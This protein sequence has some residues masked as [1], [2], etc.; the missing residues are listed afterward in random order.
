MD[1]KIFGASDDTS[2]KQT[3]FCSE[4]ERRH[5]KFQQPCLTHSLKNVGY[6]YSYLGLVNLWC[7]EVKWKMVLWWLHR[8]KFV[9]FVGKNTAPVMGHDS[10]LH[11]DLAYFM[12]ILHILLKQHAAIQTWILQG[13][14]TVFLEN[15]TVWTWKQYDCP[16]YLQSQPIWISWSVMGYQKLNPLT[17]MIPDCCRPRLLY[18]RNTKTDNTFSNLLIFKTKTTVSVARHVHTIGH[19]F[20]LWPT[21][22]LRTHGRKIVIGLCVKFTIVAIMWL[23]TCTSVCGSLQGC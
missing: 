21:D 14:L 4:D 22:A 6:I 11:W 17:K 20:C 7:T 9:I 23:Q 13:R 3:C 18:R 15:A 16:T 5:R 8:W 19:F 2:L 10:R 1:S 12:D